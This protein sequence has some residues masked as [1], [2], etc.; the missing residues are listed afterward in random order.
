VAL[1]MAADVED[2][3][4][5]RPGNVIAKG[6]STFRGRR[7]EQISGAL[8]MASDLEIVGAKRPG[9]VRAKGCRMKKAGTFKW[10]P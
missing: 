10:G 6:H 3:R 4:A 9:N 2:V 8:D 7:Q 5:R 1:D